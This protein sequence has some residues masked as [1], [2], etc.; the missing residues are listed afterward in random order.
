MKILTIGKVAEEAGVGIETV[1]FYERKGL[2]QKPPKRAVGYRQYAADDVRRIQFIKRS[3]ELGFSLKEIRE[4][5]ELNTSRRATC[6]DILDRTDRKLKEVEDKIRDLQRM[7]KT[8]VKLSKACGDSKRAAADCRVL[9]C[10]S[11]GWK[12]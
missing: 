6:S 9:D 10:F 2:I 1:R 11:T 12:C 7:K 3:Q 8:L 4:L 5:L